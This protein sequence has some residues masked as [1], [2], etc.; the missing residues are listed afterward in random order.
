MEG[1]LKLTALGTKCGALAF[2]WHCDRLAIAELLQGLKPSDVLYLGGPTESAQ[3][4]LTFAHRDK[5]PAADP[6]HRELPLAD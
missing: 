6:H 4:G 5:S 1:C 2:G 3:Q